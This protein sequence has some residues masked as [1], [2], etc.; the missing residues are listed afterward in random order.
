MGKKF[1]WERISDSLDD[2]ALTLPKELIPLVEFMKQEKSFSGSNTVFTERY[3]SFSGENL[4]PKALKQIMNRWRYALEE[5]G[6]V[7]ESH[8]SN[9][10]RLLEISFFSSGDASAVSDGETTVCVSC[11][12]SVPCVPVVPP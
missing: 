6:V 12:P 3:N 5:Q 8:R 7:F 1:V 11:V 2:P 4:S 9:G 10:Q